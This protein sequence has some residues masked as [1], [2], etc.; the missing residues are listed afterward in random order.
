MSHRIAV[1]LLQFAL[2]LLLA[3][4]AAGKFLGLPPSP[5]LFTALG[6]EPSGRFL[7]GALELLAAALLLLPLTACLGA[8]LAWGLLS[9]ALLAHFTRVG[10]GGDWLPLSLAAITGWL[11]ACLLLFLLRHRVGFLRAMFARPTRN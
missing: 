11:A 5:D 8:L 3:G 1:F 7:I 4:A 2:A 9:G 6:M 10:L